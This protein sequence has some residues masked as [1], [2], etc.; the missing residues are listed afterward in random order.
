MLIKDRFLIKGKRHHRQTHQTTEQDRE[1]EE[2]VNGFN[3][4]HLEE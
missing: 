4:H 2:T 1:E 3:I